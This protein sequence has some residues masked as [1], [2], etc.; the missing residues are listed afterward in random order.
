MRTLCTAQIHPQAEQKLR[1]EVNVL[2]RS[3]ARLKAE[4]A[5]DTA[6]IQELEVHTEALK[7][8]I[9][10][11]GTKANRLRGELAERDDVISDGYT[12]MQA[13]LLCAR[14]SAVAPT[15]ALS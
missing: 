8:T 6:R 5:A 10:E 4:K 14:M 11:A 2:L 13:R 1:A 9:A 15:A 7:A 3:N 12:A